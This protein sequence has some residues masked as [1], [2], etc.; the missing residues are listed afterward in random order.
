MCRFHIV[1]FAALVGIF[2]RTFVQGVSL[3][4]ELDPTEAPNFYELFK[5]PE[6]HL[7]LTDGPDTVN[8]EVRQY[9]ND[10]IIAILNKYEAK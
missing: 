10:P 3:P 1:V 4:N 9:I 8:W 7:S 6:A 2:L 5:N